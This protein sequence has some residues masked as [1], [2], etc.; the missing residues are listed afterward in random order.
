MGAKRRSS[1]STA[2][3][4]LSISA[5]S[6]RHRR[7]R[8]RSSTIGARRNV[9]S[10]QRSL[11]KKLPPKS[12]P[13]S[14][15]LQTRKRKQISRAIEGTKPD[16][17]PTAP[18]ATTIGAPAAGIA[19]STIIDGVPKL[20]PSRCREPPTLDR[21]ASL[22]IADARRLGG[23]S[24]QHWKVREEIETANVDRHAAWR[25]RRSRSRGREVSA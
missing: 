18:T 1:A 5:T 9:K 24:P 8:L 4:T 19:R 22:S 25:R 10:S 12:A 15:P 16:A 14:R 17:K 3:P 11:P 2:W 13:P 7:K 21:P 6:L 20:S 23:P